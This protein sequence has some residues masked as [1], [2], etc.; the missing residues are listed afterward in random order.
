MLIN[1]LES[2]HPSGATPGRKL[3]TIDVIGYGQSSID[4]RSRWSLLSL[5]NSSRVSI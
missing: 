3:Q 4:I 1:H 2:D 5:P